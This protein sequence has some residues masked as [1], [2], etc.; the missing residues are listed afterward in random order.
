[1]RIT[2]TQISRWLGRYRF[3][4]QVKLSDYTWQLRIED[5]VSQQDYRWVEVL[6]PMF[7]KDLV[8]WAN[9]KAIIKIQMNQE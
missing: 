9:I 7:A 6:G 4:K 3:N 8:S 1:M 5:D 2:F